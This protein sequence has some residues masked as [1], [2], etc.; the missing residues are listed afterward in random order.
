MSDLKDQIMQM[1]EY[2][3]KHP[4][5]VMEA[6]RDYQNRPVSLNLLGSYMTQITFTEGYNN[7]KCSSINKQP[8]KLLL[9]EDL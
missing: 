4:E 5:S 8:N 7:H 6:R 1:G 3:I 9:L 2:L